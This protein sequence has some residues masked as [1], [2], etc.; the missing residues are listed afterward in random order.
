MLNRLSHPVPLN[1]IP[2]VLTF[3]LTLGNLVHVLLL[4]HVSEDGYTD[5]DS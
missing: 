2:Y 4:R 1:E 5:F 3:I